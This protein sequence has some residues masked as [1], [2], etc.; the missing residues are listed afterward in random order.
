MQENRHLF[1]HE[2]Y[3]AEERSYGFSIR[4]KGV[5]KHISC[6]F[7]DGGDIMVTVYYRN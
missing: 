2:P 7:T 3:L 5:T 6:C 1:S 4:F